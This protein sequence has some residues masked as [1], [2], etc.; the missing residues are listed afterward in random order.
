MQDKLF[1][2][3]HLKEKIL[4]YVHPI[5]LDQLKDAVVNVF[6]KKLSFALLEMFLVE[7]KFMT[8]ALLK[9]FITSINQGFIQ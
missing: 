9:C 3:G 8:D 7:L 4:Q 5:T 1:C 6:E 2:L